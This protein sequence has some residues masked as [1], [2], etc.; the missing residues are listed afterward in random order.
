[1]AVNPIP[2]PAGNG[3]Y[4]ERYY[5][6]DKRVSSH[7]EV[8][9]ERVKHI[10]ARLEKIEAGISTINTWGLTIGFTL[11]CGMAGLIVTLIVTLIK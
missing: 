6:L 8:C 5:E 2:S 1:M 10:D 4:N 7:E 9:E 11:V 3:Y